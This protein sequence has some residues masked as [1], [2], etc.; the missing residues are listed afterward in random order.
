MVSQPVYPLEQVIAIK[1]NRFDKAI[2]TLEEKKAILEAA[3]EKLYDL[4]QELN[5]VETHRKNKLDQM[6]DALDTGTT[7]DKVQQMKTYLKIVDEKRKEKQKKV[8]D[9]QRQVDLAQAQVD[10]AT[11]DLFQKKKDLEKLEIHKKEWLKEANYI[12]ERKEE[13]EHD[14][15]GS[16]GYER[17]RREKKLRDKGDL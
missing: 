3:Y 16:T 6:R 13:V 5:E 10:L 2:K 7:S 1:K 4:T 17:I 12:V 15:Q 8:T 9:Q 11:D 14:E